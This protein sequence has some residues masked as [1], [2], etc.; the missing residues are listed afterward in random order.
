M[1][2][3]DIPVATLLFIDLNKRSFP[4]KDVQNTAFARGN[5]RMIL[6]RQCKRNSRSIYLGLLSNIMLY[7]SAHVLIIMSTLKTIEKIR[8]FANSPVLKNLKNADFTALIMRYLPSWL[9]GS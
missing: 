5:T 9:Q 4:V 2:L 6:I 7:P 1:F 3:L 8:T